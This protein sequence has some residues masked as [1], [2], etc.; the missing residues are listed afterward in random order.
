MNLQLSLKTEWFEMTKAGIKTEDYRELNEYWFKRLIYNWHDVVLGHRYTFATDENI[1]FI[2]KKRQFGFNDY[3]HNIMT[4]GYP[5]STDTE[6][7][8]KLEHK[9]IEI[10]TGNPEWG[11]EEGKLYFVIKH[12]EIIK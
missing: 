2:V 9:G 11:A 12:G 10:G 6:R 5:K 4:L 3:T 8:L 7:I 1:Q